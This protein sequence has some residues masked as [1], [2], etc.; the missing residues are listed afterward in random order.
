[1]DKAH[2][3]QIY[4]KIPAILL[5]ANVYSLHKVNVCYLSKN[6]RPEGWHTASMWK[7]VIEIISC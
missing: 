4:Y 7:A 5:T 1:M 3:V 2:G 6:Q